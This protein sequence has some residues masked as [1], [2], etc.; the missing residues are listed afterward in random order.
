MKRTKSY[1]QK[2]KDEKNINDAI[3]HQE[4]AI[5]SDEGEFL[6]AMSLQD[7]LAFAES[8]DLDLVEMG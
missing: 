4:L 2:R 7:A 5:I 1:P 6:G 3:E 8:K